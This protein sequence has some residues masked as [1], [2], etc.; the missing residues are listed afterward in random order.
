MVGGRASSAVARSISIP[1]SKFFT[2][3]VNLGQL[4]NEDYVEH[5]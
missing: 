4:N 1:V 2:W 5:K 3:K